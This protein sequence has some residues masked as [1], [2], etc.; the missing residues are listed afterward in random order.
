ML[1]CKIEER[2]VVVIKDMGEISVLLG[3]EKGSGIVHYLTCWLLSPWDGGGAPT[4]PQL[5]FLH[6]QVLANNLLHAS[7]L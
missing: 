1:I 7:A 6:H 3:S 2:Q 5:L 4:Y